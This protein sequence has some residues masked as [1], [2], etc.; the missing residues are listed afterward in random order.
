SDSLESYP[1]DM[2]KRVN[3]EILE[4][5]ISIQSILQEE[6]PKTFLIKNGY[7]YFKNINLA[8]S[9]NYIYLSKILK[10]EKSARRKLS[11]TNLGTDRLM[12]LEKNNT[13]LMD[14]FRR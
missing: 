7:A 2:I 8:L 9:N 14:V 5:I 12:Y 10:E 6:D 11:F 13:R 3:P 1:V 4:T